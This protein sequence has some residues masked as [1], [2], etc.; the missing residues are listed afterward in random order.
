[1][2]KLVLAFCL[3]IP[4]GLIAQ[5]FLIRGQLAD[6]LDGPLP[7]ATVMLLNPADSALVNFGV[8]DSRGQFIIR[9]VPAG[10]YLFKATFIGFRPSTLK[11][12]TPDPGNELDL[13]RIRMEPVSSELEAIEIEAERPPVT[14]KKDTI[15]FN[16][17]SFKTRENAMVEDLL[18]KLPGVEVDNDGNISAQGEQ[19]RRVTVDG[20][21]FFGSDPKLA[22]RNLPA[23]AINKVQVFDKK[24]DQAMFSGIDDG[25]RE[26]TINLELKEEKRN[27]MFGNL[28]AGGGTE[29]RF[30]TRASLNKFSKQ[31]QLSVLGMG[32]NVNEQGFSMEEYMNFTGG[33]QQ[34][35]GGGAVR[36]QFNAGNQ[37]G[38]PMN[39]GNRANGIMTNYA[40]GINSNNQLNARTELNG[41]YFYNYLDHAKDQNTWREN[42]LPAGSF[43]FN[44]NSRQQNSNQNHRFNSV[45]D[46][47]LDSANSIK[48]TTN[49]TWNQTG[50]DVSATSQNTLPDGTLQNESETLSRSEGQT[51]RLNSDFLYRHRFGKKGRTFSANLQF[52]VNEVER[53]GE[54]DATNTFYDRNGTRE[55]KLKQSNE[56]QNDFLSIGTTFNYTEPLGN[57]KYLETSYSY[58][59]N[60]NEVSRDVFNENNGEPVWDPLLSNDFLSNY[61]YHRGGLSFRITRSNLNVVAG[62]AVQYTELKGDLRIRDIQLA[63]TFQNLLPSARFS[64]DFSSTR[65]LRFDYETSVQEPDIQQLQPIIDNTDPLNLY[66]GNP[67]LKPSY[68]Q[69]WRWHYTAF[70]PASFVSFF[71]FANVEYTTQAITNAQ[72]VDENL[73]RTTTPV[74]VSDNLT[75]RT[76]A[77]FSFP[78][79]KLNSRFSISADFRDAKT[80]AILNDQEND[81]RQQTAGGSVRYSYRYKEILDVS[82]SADVSHQAA[83]YD[84]EQP[85][86][87]FL[88][89]TYTAEANLSFLKAYQF[90]G[91]FDF[92]QYRSS[93]TNE[94]QNI[95]LLTLSVSRFVLKNKAGEV[96]FS[97]NNVLDQAL[98]VSQTSSINYFERQT[99]NSLGRFFM[100][101]FTYA[102]NKHLNPMGMRRG[103]MIRIRR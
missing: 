22:T 26:K 20:K 31:K 19:V 8:S 51:L 78:I 81:I 27:G 1:M 69:N 90:S 40:G 3:V 77:T 6:T 16:A 72:S 23:N 50:S 47:K 11:I 93:T 96:K 14:V 54:L 79:Q 42:Y 98:G 57:R 24:S 38:V 68:S 94:P 10:A 67:S 64:Y 100:V 102:L 33:S 52:A 32:N 9:N 37:N 59:N 7:S 21:S 36:M 58:R 75:I 89:K 61:T 63:R 44:Q 99:T 41:S 66:Q 30:Q 84:F 82:L 70:N 2:K 92:L 97:L 83:K 103:G 73:V 91:N 15:E 35:M 49:L 55:E 13:G 74:N 48:V 17:G 76:D 43:T 87:T 60:R 53:S 85:D 65:H 95:P 29:E 101:S 39:F 71:A 80:I 12:N 45:V 86:Q 88:N 46:H 62:T 18:K 28:M 4:Y 25:Q 5:K 56:Q 34:M